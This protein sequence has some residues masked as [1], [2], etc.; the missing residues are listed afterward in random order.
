[1]SSAESDDDVSM[2]SSA[3]KKYYPF[4][5]PSHLHHAFSEFAHLT[6]DDQ[7]FANYLATATDI[8]PEVRDGL[9]EEKKLQRQANKSRQARTKPP[10][11]KAAADEEDDEEDD[12]DGG[13]IP[14][15]EGEAPCTRPPCLKVLSII[16]DLQFNNE[17]ERYMIED[18]YEHLQSVL[19][20]VEQQVKE[21][22]G[23]LQ[24]VSEVTNQLE[25]QYE[26]LLKTVESLEKSKEHMQLD[27][28]DTNNKIMILEIEKRKLARSLEQSKKA[29][30][31]AMWRKK[32]EKAAANQEAGLTL[33]TS[34]ISEQP[35]YQAD[36]HS[37]AESMN[38]H[39]T[40]YNKLAKTSTVDFVEMD[41]KIKNYTFF[42]KEKLIYEPES[43]DKYSKSFYD[44]LTDSH[45]ASREGQD[46]IV[47]NFVD[48]RENKQKYSGVEAKNKTRPRSDDPVTTVASQNFAS[49]D[50]ELSGGSTLFY[51][52]P[53]GSRAVTSVACSRAARRV[54]NSLSSSLSASQSLST[55]GLNASRSTGSLNL[56]KSW[57]RSKS[58][59]V[60]LAPL[61]ADNEF[62]DSDKNFG[63]DI[64][65][66]GSDS[67]SFRGGR[68]AG[69]QFDGISSIGTIGPQLNEVFYKET[70]RTK[71]GRSHKVGRVRS[72]GSIADPSSSNASVASV[73]E[74][75]SIASRH[76]ASK[77]MGSGEPSISWRSKLLTT[78][79]PGM[80]SF[81]DSCTMQSL[82]S[83]D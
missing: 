57:S 59:G 75:K 71:W 38:L 42:M 46:E 3:K 76:A 2:K 37:V 1:M 35:I 61:E 5:T 28:S 26:Q 34:A 82:H 58:S 39:K 45:E 70:A 83:E 50:N 32:K 78:H 47:L 52:D 24:D 55:A 8:E 77:S 33:A 11:K 49:L 65:N 81:I 53:D 16:A 12:D 27:R 9:E 68:S 6:N 15:M 25:L 19:T 63:G 66:W 31:D 14:D 80:D 51:Y 73:A 56:S 48:G 10:P 60:R 54:G 44:S 4:G 20:S 69:N 40:T 7:P 67:G 30:A 18:E 36:D 62:G 17:T 21:A 13:D 22:D 64:S 23:K 72:K 41:P 43:F 29:L 74:T 79:H